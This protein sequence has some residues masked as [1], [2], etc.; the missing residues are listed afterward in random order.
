MVGRTSAE[1][2]V[3]L[4]VRLKQ[5]STLIAEWEHTTLPEAPQMF[6]RVLSPAEEASITDYSLLRAELVAHS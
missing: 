6:T 1:G 5:G 3:A 2:E 4:T